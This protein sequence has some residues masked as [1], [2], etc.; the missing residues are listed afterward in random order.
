MLYQLIT[1]EVQKNPFM[2]IAIDGSAAAIGGSATYMYNLLP[3]LAQI[4]GENE[5][6]IICTQDQAK[7]TI[8]LPKN[9]RYV[10]IPLRW[11]EAGRRIWWMQTKL[12]KLLKEHHTEVLYSPNDLT[13]FF[14]PCPVVMAIRNL[15]PYTNLNTI[16]EG[17][18]YRSRLLLQKIL[19]QSS[20]WKS[21]RVIFVSNHSKEIISKQLGIPDEKGIVIHHGLSGQ[22]NINAKISPRFKR[23]Q[24][25]VL[26]V[27]TIYR[28]KN[29]ISLL[30]AFAKLLKKYRFSYS[31]LIAG[32]PEDDK[33]LAQMK[34]VI[35]NESIGSHVHLLGEIEYPK[36]PSLYAGARL[37]A[38]P[39]YLETFGHPLVEAMASG[40]PIISSN[41]SVMPE[42]CGNAALYFDPFN[43]DELA[44]VMYKLL[45]D[46]VLWNKMRQRGFERVEKNSWK[47][48]AEKTLNVLKSVNGEVIFN[49]KCSILT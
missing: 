36:M 33:Y 27:S 21:S 20:A 25:Y 15:K 12:P 30:Q 24:P 19:T 48:T 4:D 35:A 49:D 28:E 5:Y 42:I 43:S 17:L 18:R 8:S 3:S 16:G 11:N 9:F 46:N 47:K 37:F 1:T 45:T 40:L 39:S 7:W 26:S 38:F 31:L 32:R 29:Y 10:K 44:Q 22:F 6:I 14:A 41:A 23:Y 34:Q 13:S 2:K